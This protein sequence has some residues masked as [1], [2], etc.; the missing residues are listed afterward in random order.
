MS[1]KERISREEAVSFLLT[2]IVV[3]RGHT[4]EMNQ[5]N[6]FHI[7]NMATEA[8]QVLARE[9]EAIPHEV[10]EDIARRFIERETS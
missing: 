3:E 8:Q 9:E 7:T 10:M 4:F 1:R 2:H 5:L 6:L